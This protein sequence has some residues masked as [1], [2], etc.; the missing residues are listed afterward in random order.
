MEQWSEIL[1]KCPLCGRMGIRKNNLIVYTSNPPKY[2]Y[3]CNVCGY[4]EVACSEND[5]RKSGFRL[6]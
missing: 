6:K 5:L 2:E 4:N 1:C 3:E